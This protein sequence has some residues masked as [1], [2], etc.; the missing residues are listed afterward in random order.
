[1]H[2]ALQKSMTTIPH[3]RRVC[4]VAET[5]CNTSTRRT[6][7]GLPSPGA[8]IVPTDDAGAFAFCEVM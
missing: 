7:A 6:L 2:T 5:Q 8:S 1:M 4:Q 3:T